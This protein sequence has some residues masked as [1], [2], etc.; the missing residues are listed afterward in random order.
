MQT[1]LCDNESNFLYYCT[2]TVLIKMRRETP[3]PNLVKV[4]LILQREYILKMISVP[5]CPVEIFLNLTLIRII[6]P[7]VKLLY[8]DWLF[9]AY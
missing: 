9:L 6:I 1:R 8:F 7:C 3:I 5:F 2:E 4:D